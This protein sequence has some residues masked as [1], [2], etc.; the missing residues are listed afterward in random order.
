M[1]L[2][3]LSGLQTTSWI[4]F[5][6]INTDYTCTLVHVVWGR[7]GTSRGRRGTGTSIPMYCMYVYMYSDVV[8]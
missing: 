1:E 3:I 4:M 8:R 6:S 5:I 7:I 2:M